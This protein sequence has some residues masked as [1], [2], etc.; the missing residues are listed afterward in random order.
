MSEETG[1]TWDAMKIETFDFVNIV[2]DIATGNGEI[3]L[4]FL[5]DEPCKVK[6]GTKYDNTNFMFKVFVPKGVHYRDMQNIEVKSDGEEK[7][8]TVSSMRLMTELKEHLPIAN[9][10]IKIVGTGTG[11]KTNYEVEEL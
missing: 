3:K 5:E 10:T 11:M 6:K 7:V 4:T 9:K 1:F 2:K 8:F